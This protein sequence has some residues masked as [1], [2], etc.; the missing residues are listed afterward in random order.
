MKVSSN[1]LA[2]FPEYK[3][4]LTGE[5]A[6]ELICVL[7]DTVGLQSDGIRALYSQLYQELYKNADL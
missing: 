5:E 7:Y 1:S 3:I 6:K 4:T 2:L